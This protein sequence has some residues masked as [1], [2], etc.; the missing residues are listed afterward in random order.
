MKKILHFAIASSSLQP[1]NECR[2]IT[3][4]YKC[5]FINNAQKQYELLMSLQV[6]V[7]QHINNKLSIKH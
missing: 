7:Y 5:S 4:A 2:T 3:V 1:T 6:Q